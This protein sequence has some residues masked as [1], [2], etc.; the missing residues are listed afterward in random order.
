MKLIKTKAELIDALATIRGNIALVPT[1][2]ALHEGHLSLVSAALA[3]GSSGSN[4]DDLV[5]ASIFVNPLQFADLGN[6]DD[7]RNYPRTL[8]ADAKLLESA[9]VDIIFAPDVEEMYPQGTP[10]IWVRTGE[11]GAQ[12]EGAAPGTLMGSPPW[13]RSCLASSAHTAPTSGRRTPSNWRSSSAWF[14]IL[15]CALISARCPL[16]VARMGLPNPAATSTSAPLIGKMP[17]LY[18]QHSPH[19]A[20]AA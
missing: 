20:N 11:M 4:S 1:M 17:W 13:W 16:F 14:T 9:G 19:C 3:D 6:C 8:E 18:P 2:G 10:E 12:M 5:V 7:Y 15:T